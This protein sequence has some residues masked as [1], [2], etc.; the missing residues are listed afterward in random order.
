[1]EQN[2]DKTK[3]ILPASIL[4]A[5]LLISWSVVFYSLNTGKLGANVKQAEGGPVAGEKVNVSVDDDAFMGNEKAKV[6]IVEFSDFQCPFCRTFWSGALPQ[7]KKEYIDTGKV[8]F[9][10]RDYP[11]S[12][13]P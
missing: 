7:I 13:H 12:F 2:F 1:M 9:V 4:I 6:T 10:Y 3:L 11:L 5:A 8:K